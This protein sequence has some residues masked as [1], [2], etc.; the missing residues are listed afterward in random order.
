[1]KWVYPLRFTG[2]GLHF[3]GI[4]ASTG[5]HVL[6]HLVIRSQTL[7]LQRSN[8]KEFIEQSMVRHGEDQLRPKKEGSASTDPCGR[9]SSEIC[10]R[11]CRLPDSE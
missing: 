5:V 3:R 10:Y 11:P 2:L 1:M 4:A 7:A 9:A 8:D 6:Y